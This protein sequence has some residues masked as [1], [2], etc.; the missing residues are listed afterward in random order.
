MQARAHHR[1]DSELFSPAPY[2]GMRLQ[3][4]K[5]VKRFCLVPLESAQ[6]DTVEEGTHFFLRPAFLYRQTDDLLLAWAHAINGRAQLRAS[7][8]A[9]GAIQTWVG[10]RRRFLVPRHDTQELANQTSHLKAEPFRSN[11]L[12]RSE[13]YSSSEW[14]SIYDRV[15]KRLGVRHRLPNSD[16]SLLMPCLFVDRYILRAWLRSVRQR[17][18]AGRT[19]MCN[20]FWTRVAGRTSACPSGTVLISGETK[21]VLGSAHAVPPACSA[22][23]LCQE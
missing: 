19:L 13:G 2:D 23:L 17:W 20:R 7:D 22:R 4:G 6:T 8:G 12:L 14:Q 11:K 9:R 1:L 18:Q 16:Q 10:E 21:C 15:L 5:K 3:S